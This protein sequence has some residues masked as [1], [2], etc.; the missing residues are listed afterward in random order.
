MK[1]DDKKN[2]KVVDTLPR[3]I[4]RLTNTKVFKGIPRPRRMIAKRLGLERNTVT[5][6]P[7]LTDNR[8]ESAAVSADFGPTLQS[9][10]DAG[11]AV[12]LAPHA[13]W[14]S[15][16][17]FIV[18]TGDVLYAHRS[19]LVYCYHNY[20]QPFLHSYDHIQRSYSESFNAVLEF[21]QEQ[22]RNTGAHPVVCKPPKTNTYRERLDQGNI[23]ANEVGNVHYRLA[24]NAPLVKIRYVNQTIYLP[25]ISPKDIQRNDDFPFQPRNYPK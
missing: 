22:T 20:M 1:Q 19:L 8:F 10:L 5:F 24:N 14:Q 17:F 25:R 23:E 4:F 3:T 11:E 15:V 13:Q 9:F 16:L 12:I 21:F 6:G 2:G 18:V 7:T